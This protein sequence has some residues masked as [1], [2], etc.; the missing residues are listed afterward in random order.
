RHTRS[1][2]DWSSDGALPISTPCAAEQGVVHVEMFFDPQA[3]TSRGVPFA[4]VIGG[5]RQGLLAAR[6]D[7]GISAELILCML[8]DFTAEHARSEERRVGN[9]GR[10]GGSGW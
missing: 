3:H 7:L 2:R 6:R 10:A 1:K 9:E 8:R 4:D 5:Y